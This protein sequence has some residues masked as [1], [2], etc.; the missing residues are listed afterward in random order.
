MGIASWL[1]EIVLIVFITT[2]FDLLLPNGALTNFTR[3]VMGLF[4]LISI[5]NPMICLLEEDALLGS[6]HLLQST[7]EA[8]EVL[9]QGERLLQEQSQKNF[10]EYALHLEQQI[11]ALVYLMEGVSECE[12]KVDMD[13][14][15]I[16]KVKITVNA[17]ADRQ[18]IVRLIAMYYNFEQEQ[19]EVRVS[20]G[21]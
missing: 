16:N 14:E 21:R 7:E 15:R 20:E 10:N 12:T 11:T 5:L 8:K 2:F 6:W 4:L 9:A 17:Q 13:A 19:I 3:M 1:E 18:Q